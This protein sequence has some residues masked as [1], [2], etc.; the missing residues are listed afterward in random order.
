[1]KVGP[2]QSGG[3]C[4]VSGIVLSGIKAVK[5][6]TWKVEVDPKSGVI[7]TV[8][9]GTITK[10]DALDSAQEALRR[11]TG[12]GPHLF[13]TDVLDAD[14]ELTV[15]DI[16]DVPSHWE[17]IGSNRRSKLALLVPARGPMWEDSRFYETVCREEGW[18]VKVFSDKEEA[19]DWLT[20]R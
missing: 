18:N 8:Y 4:V 13:L 20:C 16:F 9:V 6:K 2:A 10:Q 7:L 11:A 3:F 17:A 19:I 5:H 12:R 15:F 14:S 1:M